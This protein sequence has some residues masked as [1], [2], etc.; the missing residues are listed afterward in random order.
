MERFADIAVRLR[1]PILAAWLVLALAGWG[2]SAG[3]QRLL[4]D[5]FV[6]PGTDTEAARTILHDAFGASDDAIFLLVVETPGTTPTPAQR[7]ALAAAAAAAARIVPDGQVRQVFGSGAVIVAPIATD[8]DLVDA[9]PYTDA[10]R[11]A[12]PAD[13]V[14]GARVAVSGQPAIS[15]D[16]DPVIQADIRTGE[17]IAIPIAVVVLLFIFGSALSALVPLAFAFATVG[18]TLGL[19]W[20]YAHLIT[21]AT[22]TQYLVTLIGL[23]IAID[24]SLL[25]VYRFREELLARQRAI[26]PAGTDPRR[27]PVPPDV[28][29]DCLRTTMRFSGHAVVFSGLTVAVGLASLMVIPLPY[30]RSMG[31]GGLFIPLVSIAAA[32]TLL[33]ALLALL[34]HRVWS[35]RL[36]PTRV[37]D[38]RA[39]AGSGMWARLAHGI[40]RRPAPYLVLG[41][42]VLVALVVPAFGMRLTPGSNA[43]LPSTPE[44]MQGYRA[45]EREVGAGALAPISVVVDG[46]A[47]GAIWQPATADAIR[48]LTASLRADPRVNGA[49]AVQAPT[50]L[51]DAGAT[52]AVAQERLAGLLVDATGRYARISASTRDEYGSEDA[53]ALVRDLRGSLVAAAGFPPAVPVL[54]GGG[55]AGGVDFIDVVY[56]WFPLLIAI[57]I[58]STFVLLVRAFRS[59]LLPVK[60]IVLNLLSVG[61][62]YGVLVLAFEHGWGEPFG[63]DAAPQVEAWI[64]IFLFAMLFGL[65]MDYEVFLVSRMREAYDDGEPTADAVAT[66]LERTGRLVTAAALIMVAAFAGFVVGSFLGL[67]QFGLGLA[68]AILLDATLVRMILVPSFMRVAGAWNWWLPERLERRLAPRPAPASEPG[69]S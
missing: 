69:G 31:L 11:A 54:V 67:R 42:A 13:A 41:A 10:L 18:T 20:I 60:A 39:A 58:V 19:V 28:L 37:L 48:R 3:L 38:A 12:L 8:L 32:V 4:S 43:G 26:A 6:L 44:S 1:W 5:Q 23:G 66:G 50:D 56:R 25:V 65:S 33:P 35:I 46:G 61:A 9:K 51:V 21:T 34:G 59:L 45:L 64:P 2:A 68:A 49:G 53:Q 62:A 24:Y 40:M 47:P 55:P 22:P 16:L 36:V 15:H 63:L 27:T 57:V 29:L 52:P 14:P 30:I 17:A 7:E